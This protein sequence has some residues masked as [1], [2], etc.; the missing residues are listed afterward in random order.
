ML[1]VFFGRSTTC[2][3]TFSTSMNKFLQISNTFLQIRKT[4]PTKCTLAT[5]FHCHLK[6]YSREVLLSRKLFCS[7]RT[8]R[9]SLPQAPTRPSFAG[10]SEEFSWSESRGRED[11]R[12]NIQWWTFP[13]KICFVTLL[14]TLGDRS[15]CRFGWHSIRRHKSPSC[16]WHSC[17][18]I[19]ASPKQIES[20]FPTPVAR[21]VTSPDMKHL[22]YYGFCEMPSP[23]VVVILSDHFFWRRQSS[24]KDK[25][26]K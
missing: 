19:L 2:R 7:R 25:N 4:T 24:S 6:A 9:T 5:I 8:A 23:A 12:I 26:L 17:R 1:T 21:W 22:R 10:S 18:R 15:G 3:C 14:H 13:L 11:C 16:T 20:V